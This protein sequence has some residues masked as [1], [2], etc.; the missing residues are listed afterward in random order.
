MFAFQCDL[1]CD[2]FEANDAPLFVSVLLNSN[3]LLATHIIPCYIGCTIHAL[4]L[5]S[6]FGEIGCIWFKGEMNLSL[7]DDKEFPIFE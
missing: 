2:P 1:A 3:V 6:Q 5:L 7:L 4:N